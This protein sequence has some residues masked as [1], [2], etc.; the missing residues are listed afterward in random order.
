LRCA[1]AGACATAAIA[2]VVVATA[3]AGVVAAAAIAALACVRA[4]FYRCSSIFL[5]SGKVNKYASSAAWE[6]TMNLLSVAASPLRWLNFLS[7]VY[8][9]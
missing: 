9:S 4:A 5:A 6:N 1:A 7:A 8:N 3:I 2:G